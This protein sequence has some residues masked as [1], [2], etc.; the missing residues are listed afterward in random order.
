MALQRLMSVTRTYA[1][2]VTTLKFYVISQMLRRCVI[3]LHLRLLTALRSLWRFQPA[4]RRR[5]L[6]GRYARESRQCFL[7]A[8]GN[9]P[10]LSAGFGTGSPL[11]LKVG[12]KD[13]ISGKE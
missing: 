10:I 7:L 3:L 9:L 11:S 1:L 2:G 12:A 13:G 4:A 6:R 8:M 5:L